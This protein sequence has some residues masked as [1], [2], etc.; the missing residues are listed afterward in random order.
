MTAQRIDG[1]ALGATILDEV[2][3]EMKRLGTPPGLAV[4]LVG[5]DPASHLYVSLK[6]K[7]A[8]DLGMHFERWQLPENIDEDTLLVKVESLNR[9]PQ[10]HGILVQ[11]PLPTHLDTNNV[12]RTLRPEKDVD[13]FHPKNIDALLHGKPLVVPGLAV[14]ILWLIETTGVPLQGKT[15]VILANSKIF[16]TPVKRLLQ[17]KGVRV[18]TRTAATLTMPSTTLTSADILITALGK[19][20][21]VLPKHV[22]EGA[23]VIDVGTTRV[24]GKLVGDVH[25][26][27]KQKAGWL[28]PVPGG[29]GPVTVAMLLKNTVA[30]AKRQT[31]G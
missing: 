22:K 26:D 15:A 18:Q 5:N 28:T 12:I 14:G 4:V 31:L 19:P 30:A 25:P 10:I 16:S 13:G 2:K 17:E 23:I 3:E 24:N 9:D 20:H 29:V 6:E 27:V 21:A 7:S 1:T 11:L 8:K